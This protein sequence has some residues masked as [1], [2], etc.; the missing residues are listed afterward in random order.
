M[1]FFLKVYNYV[2]KSVTKLAT[3]QTIAL[4]FL[5]VILSGTFLLSLPISTMPLETTT[6]LDA[7]FTA[8]SSVCVTGLV[9]FNTFE[10]W[11][12]FGQIVIMLLIQIGGLGLMTLVTMAFVFLGKKITLKDR[13]VIQQSFNVS[14]LNGMVRLVRYIILGTFIIESCGAIILAIRF[15]LEPTISVP[16]A[17]WFGVFHSISAFCNAGFDILGANSLINYSGDF[18][19][20]IVVMLLIVLGGLGFTV[21]IDIT[22]LFEKTKNKSFNF[23]SKVQHFSTNSK[24]ALIFT[25]FLIL[26]GTIFFFFAEYNNPNTIG[27]FGFFHKILASTFQSVTLR[28]AGFC[29]VPQDAMTY[30]SKFISILFM[31]VG[32]SPGGTA[33]G[34][35]TVTSVVIL[36]AVISVLHGKNSILIFNKSIPFNLLQ[37][38]LAIVTLNAS[39][40]G[41]STTILTFTE[42]NSA[43]QYE[44]I[45]LLFETV[46]ATGT[47]GLTTGITPFLSEAGKIV[48]VFCMFLGRIGSITAILSLY[49]KQNNYI[50]SIHY[51]E[52][53]VMIG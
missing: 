41:I 18:T 2:I 14:N 28:T 30:A 40:I 10:H 36:L 32:G 49:N 13:L 1:N 12:L 5:L 22:K 8:T 44:F 50:N 17:I 29:T 46:S 45:D 34:I 42:V 15:A 31:F 51:P 9:V 6:I 3:L 26:S 24:I 47:V 35:K 37:K 39:I 11:T 52:E 7:L 38:A 25:G 48:I 19:V 33:G 53:K 43:F 16:K 20:S 27:E 4:G 21:W 23:K